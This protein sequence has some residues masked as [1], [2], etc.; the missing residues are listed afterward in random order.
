MRKI[1]ITWILGTAL[2]LSGMFMLVLKSNRARSNDVV[3]VTP[4]TVYPG[5]HQGEISP[6]IY[7]AGVEW[8]ENGNRIFDPDQ[9][10]SR[11]EIIGLLKPLR[12]PVWRFPGGIFADY[13][14]WRDGIG[15]RGQR[16]RRSNP[17]DGTVHANNF[18][19]DEFIDFCKALNS[20]PLITANFGTGSLQE[21]LEWQKYFVSKGLP[22]KF[23][24]IGNE[25]YLAE[26]R[27]HATIPGNDRRI[28]KTPSQYASGFGQWA[29]ALR[30]ADRQ[31]QIGAI[32][33]TYNTSPQNRD[34][35]NTLLSGA[36][37]DIDFVALHNAY[38]PLIFG[39]Y[40]F[41]NQRK[42]TEAYE[43]MFAQAMFSADDIRQVE[44]A[45]A[46][47]HSPAPRI[48]ITEHFPLFGG[49]GSQGQ[50]MA[51]LDQSR[52]LAAA[53]YTASLFHA[54]MREHVWMA[55]YN[56][57]V[58]KWF[59]ALLT[60]TDNGIIRT[61]TFHVFDLYR[62]HFG[63]TL[64]RVVA[65]SPVISTNQIG[66]VKPRND[67]P[68]LDAVASQ[69]S[70]GSTYLAVINR[71]LSKAIE[72]RINVDGLPADSGAEV[73][74]LA[75]SAPNAVNGPSLSPSTQAGSVDS[76]TLKAA[77]WAAVNDGVYTV[78]AASLTIFKWTVASHAP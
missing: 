74:T 48:A 73:I 67:V 17:M 11:P 58:S 10:R 28:F 18:G 25:I 42:R 21:A 6:L 46:S 65:G 36:G 5:Q 68:S 78:Q 38:A 8:T 12:I 43:A 2:G 1:E 27:E 32:A 26:P 9:G 14:H 61:P 24:E 64:V 72:A 39:R 75:G 50:L 45:A 34:W 37:H 77:S 60:D 56:I 30:A 4:I 15:P 29:E 66:V 63:N 70:S 33:G 3:T 55:N 22:V 49:G 40:D 47:A 16:P 23:W 76:V 71:S 13:Y 69:D 20:E 59:G 53:L 51:I 54:F 35:L 57:A 19:T 62:N 7:G 41:T 44:Q 52:T 31:T